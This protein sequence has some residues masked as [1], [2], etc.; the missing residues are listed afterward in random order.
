MLLIYT[1]NTS[2]RLQYTCHFIFK[3]YLGLAYTLTTHYDSFCSHEGERIL[4][5]TKAAPEG[6]LTITPASLLFETDL[7][8]Q[9]IK[10]TN[11]KENLSFFENTSGDFPF[12]VLAATFY[13]LSRYEEYQP[14]EKDMYG[15]Y[16]HENS[17]AF[18][19]NFLHLPLVN[20]W[21]NDLQKTLERKF[22]G[23][24]CKPVAFNFLP[25]YD[26]DIAFSYRHKGLVRNLGGFLRHPSLSRIKVLFGMQEDDFASYDYLDALHNRY[27]L[28]PIYFF[29]AATQNSPYDKNISPYSHGMWQLLKRHARKY[30]IGLHPSWRSYNVEKLIAK[31]KK[32]LET[33]AH[34]TID[35]S[36][37]HYIKF[38]L[39]ETFLQ[40]L[41]AGI[42]HDYSMG[43]GSI[44][45]F[46]ASVGCSFLWYNLAEEKSTT[47]R[48]HPF[49]FMDA[50]SFYEEKLNIEEAEKELL[51]YS[52][53]CRSN[54]CE[55]ITIFHNQF[56][57]TDKKFAGYRK[58]YENFIA[59][60]G[61]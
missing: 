26:I 42:M 46:R 9:D 36:R 18:K 44:N 55:M 5:S 52:A 20:I 31:E 6:V 37:Q 13:L 32:I 28:N 4:Y 61:A 39:P 59:Q 58:L 40:L 10:V 56:L 50:N 54:N 29:L 21:L 24:K 3:E 51:E 60:V 48:L 53:T 22:R 1:D 23:L 33:A 47:L 57:G 7:R 38:S 34:N 19:N 41:N 45:G 49:C 17:L 15:R 35:S 14:H 30:K 27:T 16:A 12:D 25:T 11:G 43:Y 8:E 2:A